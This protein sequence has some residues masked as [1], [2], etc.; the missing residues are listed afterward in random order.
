MV[1]HTIIMAEDTIMAGTIV[2][3]TITIMDIDIAMG[4]TIIEVIDTI[5]V[6]DTKHKWGIT[7]IIRL[8]NNTITDI[9]TEMNAMYITSTTT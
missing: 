9:P 1:T 8:K 4:T 5:M 7:G 3:G 2:A 6:N